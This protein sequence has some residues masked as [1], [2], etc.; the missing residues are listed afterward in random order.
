MNFIRT[1][2]AALT[3]VGMIAMAGSAHA[4]QDPANQTY[5]APAQEQGSMQME[6]EQS[7]QAGQFGDDKL[8]AYAEAALEIGRINA[9]MAPEIRAADSEQERKTK[10]LQ[11]QQDMI[12]AIQNTA[13]ITMQ[14]YNQI[15][16]AMRDNP[17]LV[18][19]VRTLFDEKVLQLREDDD[20]RQEQNPVR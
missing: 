18:E 13:G 4:G 17:K 5:Q 3:A 20:L 2:A 10:T 6:Q 9:E 8:D 1:K 16:L 12:N 15:S 11:M 14:E 7:G 19:R